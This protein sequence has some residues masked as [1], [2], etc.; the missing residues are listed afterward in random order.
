MSCLVSEEGSQEAGVSSC[1]RAADYPCCA[2]PS[3]GAG[4]QCSSTSR[5][6]RAP[7]VPGRASKAE[8]AVGSFLV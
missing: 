4:P 5:V 6:V 7:C 3:F 8:L 1:A 2:L